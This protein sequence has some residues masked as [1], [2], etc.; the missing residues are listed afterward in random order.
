MKK[1]EI[2]VI[3]FLV[4]NK[5]ALIAAIFVT[6]VSIIVFFATLINPNLYPLLSLSINTPWGVITSIFLHADLWHLVSNL[7]FL[8]VWLLYLFIALRISLLDEVGIRKRLKFFVVVIFVAAIVVNIILVIVWVFLAF[9]GSSTRGSSGLVYAVIGVTFGFYVMNMLNIWRGL[10]VQ[11]QQITKR[12]KVVYLLL[13]T[14]MVIFF[15]ILVSQSSSFL[16]VGPGVNVFAHSICFLI[17]FFA[18]MMREEHLPGITTVIRK[19]LSKIKGIYKSAKERITLLVLFIILILF[20][21]ISPSSVSAL[22]L[23]LLT[24]WLSFALITIMMLVVWFGFYKVDISDKTWEELLKLCSNRI[25][26]RRIRTLLLISLMDFL[27]LSGSIILL[28]T[29]GIDNL[30]YALVDGTILASAIRISVYVDKNFAKKIGDIIPLFLP[31]EIFYVGYKYPQV[32]DISR[33]LYQNLYFF[34]SL[35]ILVSFIVCF[36]IVISK[37][38][39]GKIKPKITNG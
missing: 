5:P 13:N 11:S 34:F 18:V 21:L 32:M 29:I 27:Y 6:V 37:W 16:S 9:S 22:V 8:W 38:H 30:Q 35:L 26:N 17:G 7:V 23:V 36:E 33:F 12:K 4:E 25:L 15:L 24:S 10:N 39:S 31:L 1:I 3:G 28:K 2:D 20:W 19:N 14:F